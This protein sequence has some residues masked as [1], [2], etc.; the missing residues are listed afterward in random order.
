MR[1]RLM[2][3]VLPDR[4]DDEIDFGN[5]ILEH[6]RTAGVQ[7]AHKEDRIKFTSINSSQANLFLVTAVMMKLKM[8][9]PHKNARPFLLALNMA[10]WGGRILLLQHE[11]RDL[12][13]DVL[14][15]CAFNY[16]AHSSEIDKLADLPILKARMNPTY[17]WLMS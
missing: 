13:F 9:I 10:R 7:Q 3:F 15:C 2:A 14:V 5:V 16:D 12:Q 11:A 4:S 6:L 8:K 1:I 17:I